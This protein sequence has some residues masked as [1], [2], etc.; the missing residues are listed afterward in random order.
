M[1][2]L[3]LVGRLLAIAPP[4]LEGRWQSLVVTRGLMVV[5]FF[6]PDLNICVSA[7]YAAFETTILHQIYPDGTV[8][9]RSP[10]TQFQVVRKLTEMSAI[11]RMAQQPV[12]DII[13]TS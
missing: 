11:L 3:I 9:Q 2:H 13:M 8:R 1:R 10:D 5:A 7:P 12:S 6:L 4:S